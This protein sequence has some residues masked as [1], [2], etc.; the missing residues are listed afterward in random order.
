MAITNKFI[1]TGE[2]EDFE[3]VFNI[4][5][6]IVSLTISASYG[7]YY[8]LEEDELIPTSQYI[9]ISKLDS[10]LPLDNEQM[11]ELYNQLFE[12]IL[13]TADTGN[14][15]PVEPDYDLLHDDV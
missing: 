6:F 5:G 13:K 15:E 7:L 14:A 1:L 8:R 9:G 10:D 4:D 3:N 11:N 2:L 12:Y